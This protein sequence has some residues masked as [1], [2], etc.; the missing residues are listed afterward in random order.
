[1]RRQ[2]RQA[3]ARLILAGVAMFATG[4]FG[5]TI[6][7]FEPHT[8]FKEA[9]DTGNPGRHA[10]LRAPQALVSGGARGGNLSFNV[11]YM[12]VTNNT[13]VGFDDPTLGA[14]RQATAQAVL[15]YVDS[16]LNETSGA[17]IDVTFNNSETGGNGFL[18]SAGTFFNVSTGFINGFCF[19]HITTGTD[20]NGS[21]DDIQA[22][23]DFGFNWNSDMGAVGGSEFD[24]FTVLLHEITHGLGFFGMTGSNGNSVT[25]ASNPG[26]YSILNQLTALD[27]SGSIGTGSTTALWTTTGGA[28]YV[29][30]AGNLTGGR[31]VFTGAN[32]VAAY[33]SNPTIYSHSPFASGSSISHWGNDLINQA[34][35]PASV[36]PNVE[37]RSYAAFEVGA[38]KDLGYS[39][40]SAGPPPVSDSDQDLLTDDVETDTGIY[41]SPT[42]TGSDPNNPD[43]DG[44]G[45]IDGTEV[46]LGTDPNNPLDFPILPLNVALVMVVALGGIGIVAFTR[47]HRRASRTP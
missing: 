22:T 12:D 25:T 36:A 47:M 5:E 45:V 2:L 28:S 27:D 4:A 24:L 33:G 20:P 21:V 32:A 38:L 23:V 37:N 3:G 8:G 30:T 15:A 31:L 11:T 40:A 17:T 34:V 26:Q 43:T 41:V 13:N 14:T 29:G 1:M 6:Y 7:Y 19:T 44:D 46:T 39:N 35:M 18:A 16:I 42:D 10:S 9:V